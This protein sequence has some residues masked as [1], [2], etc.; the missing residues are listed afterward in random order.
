[1]QDQFRHGA[2]RLIL[3][4]SAFTETDAELSQAV[5]DFWARGG[6]SSQAEGSPWPPHQWIATDA[7]GFFRSDGRERS[8][9]AS[10]AGSLPFQALLIIIS[11]WPCTDLT[12]L[13]TWEGWVGLQ[14]RRSRLFFTL[15]MAKIEAEERRPYLY[16]HDVGENVA[17]MCDAHRDVVI[18]CFGRARMPDG[19]RLKG[20]DRMSPHQVLV[21]HFRSPSEG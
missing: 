16:V 7:W 12:R 6:V 4:A 5:A 19:Y 2:R 18:Q 20:M 11:G 13:A 9:L 1:M 21:W 15:P 8:P 17:T 10:F 3:V 14:G